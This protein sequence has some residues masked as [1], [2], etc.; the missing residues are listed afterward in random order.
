MNV[1][2]KRQA[3]PKHSVNLDRWYSI[4]MY[5]PNLPNRSDQQCQEEQEADREVP[6]DCLPNGR[7]ATGIVSYHPHSHCNNDNSSFGPSLFLFF[8]VFCLNHKTYKYTV[9]IHT[10][11][12]RRIYHIQVFSNIVYMF[13]IQDTYIVLYIT[14][15]MLY[16]IYR[17][18]SNEDG[19]NRSQLAEF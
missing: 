5:Q 14:L 12:E 9:H 7:R 17:I 4:A 3:L 10:K 13:C 19:F 6:C 1:P 11:H 15:C 16:I 2:G 18:Q 8:G